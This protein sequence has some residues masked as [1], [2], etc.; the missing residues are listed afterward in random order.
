MCSKTVVLNSVYL[1]Q[2]CYFCCYGYYVQVGT[3]VFDP[4]L[5][6]ASENVYLGVGDR[7]VWNRSYV[8]NPPVLSGKSKHS[9][10]VADLRQFSQ[11]W[12]SWNSLLEDGGNV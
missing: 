3:A 2:C 1:P 8:S 6:T 12:K 10:P 9:D 11:L 5:E 4:L 7:G